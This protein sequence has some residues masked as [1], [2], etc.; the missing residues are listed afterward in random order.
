MLLLLL[1]NNCSA[2]ELEDYIRSI[3]MS[4]AM[5]GT[6]IHTFISMRFIISLCNRVVP[7]SSN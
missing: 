3:I 6:D 7:F 5:P 2:F 1:A 4:L